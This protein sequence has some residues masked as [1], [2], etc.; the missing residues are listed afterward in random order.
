MC[1]TTETWAPGRTTH[2]G[3]GWSRLS[4]GGGAVVDDT[5]DRIVSE[6]AVSGAWADCGMITEAIED[7]TTQETLC[8]LI[9]EVDAEVGVPVEES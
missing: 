9:Q 6:I 3:R 4:E 5:G 7:L 2:S 8:V 1:A